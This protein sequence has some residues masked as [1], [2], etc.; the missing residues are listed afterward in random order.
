MKES[1]IARP[2]PRPSY[3]LWTGY[4][5]AIWAVIFAGL[6][7]FWAAGGRTGLQP[8]EQAPESY[9]TLFAILNVIAGALKL[10]AAA[11]V[12]AFARGIELPVSRRLVAALLWITGIGMLLYG[13]A[14]LVS[15]ALHVSGVIHDPATVKWF[16]IY[17]VLWDPWWALGG[18][19]VTA[20]A[21]LAGRR[22]D[23]T[24]GE[25]R[26]RESRTI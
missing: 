19:L 23:N 1:R 12:V 14:G 16:Y 10:G 15:D 6:S 24:P 7:F 4:A 18:A 2:A 3:A 22:G 9:T 26:A 13:G 8:L 17:L 21:W 11:V 25:S 20:T 5:A